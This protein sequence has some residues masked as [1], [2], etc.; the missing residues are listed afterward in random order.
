MPCEPGGEPS[1]S[2]CGFT[3]MKLALTTAAAGALLAAA[4]ASAGEI[5]GGLYVHDVD[6][7]LTKSNIE[8]GVDLELG[9]RG[10]R[11][12]ALRFIGSPSPQAYLSLN[13][14]GNAHFAAAGIAWKI[15]GRVYVRPGVG[16]AVH[17]GPG[18]VVPGDDRID[19]GS[20][21][22]FAPEIGLGTRLSERV[23]IE[24][25]WVHLSHGQLFG[26]QN[27]GLDTIGFRLNY[28]FK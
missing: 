22:L 28:R 2:A 10:E 25:S 8:E 13:S 5:F 15:G 3:A 6:T 9:W 14:N 12:R 23:S 16:L 26:G 1:G 17:T 27:P 4:P 20:R 24:A 19:F 21:V 11:I 7:G 18:R